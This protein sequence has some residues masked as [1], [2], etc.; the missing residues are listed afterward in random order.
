MASCAALCALEAVLPH[1]P[2][3]TAGRICAA[4]LQGAWFIGVGLVMFDREW[5]ASSAPL[6]S[7]V[8]PPPHDDTLAWLSLDG[9]FLFTH[10]IRFDIVNP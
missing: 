9:H 10:T 6:M 7:D 2:L 3:L 1:V 8:L 4:F 5:Y